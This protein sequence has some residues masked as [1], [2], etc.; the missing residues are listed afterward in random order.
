MMDHSTTILQVSQVSYQ[1]SVTQQTILDHISF[2][3]NRGDRLGIIGVSGSGKTTL[4][5]L[6][7]RL[8]DPTSGKILLNNKPINN[9]PVTH[10]RQQILLV[11]QEPKLLGMTVQDALIYPLKLQQVSPSE[12]KQRVIEYCELFSI[13]DDWLER[14]ELQLSV[15]QRQW[16]TLVR[17]VIL[18]P[19]ILLLDEPTSALDMGLANQLLEKLTILCKD[20]NLTVI[21]INHQLSWLRQ[22]ANKIIH[23]Q[24]GKIMQNSDINSINWE[25]LQ[26]QLITHR[27]EEDWET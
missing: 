8:T 22:F 6:L 16:V 7:N 27:Q 20:Q 10:L 14:N 3:V 17:G 21:M 24:S 9:Y 26:E 4:L 2:E 5:R 19:T 18:K 11:P 15:G 12:I 13:P 25:K 23:L 1:T